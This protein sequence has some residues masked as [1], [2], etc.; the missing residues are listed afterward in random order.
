MINFKSDGETA[1]YGIYIIVHY[2]MN[3]NN[4]KQRCAMIIQ[5][6]GGNYQV[7]LRIIKTTRGRGDRFL[8]T[9][10]LQNPVHVAP[11]QPIIPQ[12]HYILNQPMLQYPQQPIY[13]QP[14]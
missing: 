5:I 1:S 4:I 6:N 2:I 3:H 9:F 11:N 10:Q 13:T 14:M 8:L 7:N 12:Q